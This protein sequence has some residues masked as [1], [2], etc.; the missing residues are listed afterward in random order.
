M[1]NTI[2][3]SFDVEDWF[4][5]QNMKSI[6]PFKEWSKCELRVY[7][8]TKYILWC[9]KKHNAKATFFILGWIAERFPELVSEIAVEGHEIATHGY[10]HTSILQMTKQEFQKD[11]EKSITILNNIIQQPINGF[12]APSFSITKDTIW[13]LDILRNL[14]IQYDSSIFPIN[15]PDYGIADFPQRIH[16]I[17]GVIEVPLTSATL[18]GFKIPVSGGGYFRLYPYWFFKAMLQTTMSNNATVAYFHP[19]EFDPYQPRIDLPILKSFRHYV[20]LGRNRNKFEKFLGD[21]DFVT[22]DE[23]IKHHG[24]FTRAAVAC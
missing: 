9:L 13:A 17:N 7:E 12:R 15:H 20:G 1:M 4:C 24:P 14:G 21:F 19:W 8:N 23:K 3:L 2:A 22:I 18:S 11:T 16:R 5:V 10:S 6:F